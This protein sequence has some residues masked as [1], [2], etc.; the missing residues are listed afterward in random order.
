MKFRALSNFFIN[1]LVFSLGFTSL[2]APFIFPQARNPGMQGAGFPMMVSLI[3]LLCILIVFFEAQ[4][5][6]LD[7]KMIA[8][9]GILVAINAGLRFIENAIPGPAGFSPVFFLIILVGYA[10]GS[11]A[12][13]LI[14]A[15][16]LFVSALITGGVGPWLPGQMITAGWVGQSA[17]LLA[18]PIKKMG[19]QTKPEEVILL[20]AFGAFWG[21]LFG[22]IMNLWFWPFLGAAT[23]QSFSQFSS[24]IE[25]FQ[26]YS[27]YYLATSFLWDITRSVGN[28]VLLL[29][30]AKPVL[31]ILRRF[32]LRF[33]FYY[34]ESAHP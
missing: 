25:N 16:T 4:S 29:A 7:T 22:A 26:R 27:A 18:Y 9:L 30:L 12:G 5:A 19:W 17:A 11:Q 15:L 33:K 32:H 23:G 24:L 20:A 3:I 34:Q 14:G 21:L 6:A 10:Y 8:L 28:I 2:L 31:R 13:F 1:L